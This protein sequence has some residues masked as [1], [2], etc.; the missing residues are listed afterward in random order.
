VVN[1]T[2]SIRVVG[3]VGKPND[4]GSPVSGCVYHNGAFIVN[5]TAPA[6]SGAGVRG[7]GIPY[8]VTLPDVKAGDVLD[9]VLTGDGAEVTY[10]IDDHSTFDFKVYTV[11]V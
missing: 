8:D 7:S 9:F 4:G 5:I 6:G 11:K 2:G 1:V 10:P 3:V